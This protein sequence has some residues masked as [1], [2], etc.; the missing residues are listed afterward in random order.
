MNRYQHLD[1]AVATL[2][3]AAGAAAIMPRFRGLAD[4]DIIEKTPG[5]VVTIAD[6]AAEAML[7][8]GLTRLDAGIRVVGEEACA[9][10][11]GLLDGLD[12]GAVWLVDPLDGTANFAA[13]RRPFGIMVALLVD[14]V[15]E[16][17]WLYDPVANRMCHAIR[18]GG[19]F[20]DGDRIRV[21]PVASGRPLAALATQFMQA[22]ERARIESRA[23]EA[24]DLV[25]IPRCAAEHYPR[26]C[27]ADNEIAMFQRTLPW[28]HAAGA[29]LLQEV[30]GCVARWDGSPYRVADGRNGLIAAPGEALWGLAQT[31]LFGHV[32]AVAE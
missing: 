25:P 15:T 7:T 29:L 13:G 12:R 11:P 14:G 4:G 2:V 23:A 19:A 10:D 17:G 6:R 18:G 1:R 5:E 16:A 30:G 24:F 20:I 27:L 31:A 9:A 28:D 21:H 32:A 22:E 8:E 26:L 3:R